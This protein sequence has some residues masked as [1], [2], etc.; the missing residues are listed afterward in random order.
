[1]NAPEFSRMRR[2]NMKAKVSL[3]L[4]GLFLIFSILACD[5]SVGNL[6]GGQSVRGSGSV[7][8]ESRSVS[9][10]SKVELAMPGTLHISI[11]SSEELQIEAEDNLLEYI[12]TNVRGNTLRIETQR[13]INLQATRPIEYYLT[14][15]ELEAVD[16]S[17]SG[18]VEVKDLESES[19]S[20]SISSS[21]NLLIS[22]LVGDSLQVN[23]SSS[24]D[25]DILGGEVKEQTIRLSSSGEYHARDLA[26]TG[27]DVTLSSSGDATVRVSERL[28]GRLSS[29]GNLYYIGNP[30]L[31]VSMSS[32]GRTEQID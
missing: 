9:G 5:L 13:G 28:T 25:L 14:V 29:S 3:G 1:M 16:I 8:E 17:S 10:V 15:A 31:D 7:V 30:N 19:F 18:D 21:G 24:G 20:A 12:Q 27:A 23:I 32:S 11:G 4:V 6:A 22:N 26:S 2:F